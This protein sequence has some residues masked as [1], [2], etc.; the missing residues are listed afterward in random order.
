M[1]VSA[2]LPSAPSPLAALLPKPAPRAAS[3]RAGFAFENATFRQLSQG[4]GGFADGTPLLH[5][6]RD[7]E[8]R[9]GL[10][11]GAL[12]APIVALG[13]ADLG[14]PGETL[15]DR[16]IGPSVEQIADKRS[17]DI[18]RAHVRD[19]GEAR[20]ASEDPRDPRLRSP[21][22]HFVISAFLRLCSLCCGRKRALNLGAAEP[23]RL[24][25]FHY[26]FGEMVAQLGRAG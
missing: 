20:E 9:G 8:Q 16:Q 10:G 14:V 18:V 7:A 3:A 5:Q 2:R 15:H 19:L 13:G 26:C 17:P 1:D 6:P 22:F 12:A 21:L 11:R 24:G 25:F 4:R 23:P